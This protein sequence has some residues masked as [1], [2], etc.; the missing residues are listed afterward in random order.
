MSEDFIKVVLYNMEEQ[1]FSLCACGGFHY[2][3][4]NY[5]AFRCTDCKRLFCGGMTEISSNAPEEI[6]KYHENLISQCILMW[7]ENT[8]CRKYYCIKCF[9]NRLENKKSYCCYD[10][11]GF[12]C[13]TERKCNCVTVE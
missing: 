9:E 4:K 12:W 7:C 2:I 10:C 11:G 6:K 5:K 3:G 13:C 1:D 8:E